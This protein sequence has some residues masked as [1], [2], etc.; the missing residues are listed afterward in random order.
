M[1]FIAE[2]DTLELVT[3]KNEKEYLLTGTPVAVNNFTLPM[4]SSLVSGTYRLSFRLYDNDTLIGEVN[5]YI[6]IK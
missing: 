5:R 6:I 1:Q 4:K 3:E 2:N